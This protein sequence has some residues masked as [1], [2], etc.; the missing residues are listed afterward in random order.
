MV[1]RQ[2]VCSDVSAEQTDPTWYKNLKDHHLMWI[3]AQRHITA[4]RGHHAISA[5]LLKIYL[6]I[7]MHVLIHP[8]FLL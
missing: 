3:V 1:S 6:D 5:E 8:T 7:G 4:T 2:E